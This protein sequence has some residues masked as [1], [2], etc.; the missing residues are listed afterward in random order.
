MKEVQLSII[1]P[2]YNSVTSL[3][4]AVH[5]ILNQTFTDFELILVDD[6]SKDGSGALCDEL[7]AADHRIRVIHQENR[8]VSAARNAGLNVASG[9]YIGWVDSD[10]WISPI[11]FELM[12]ER[13]LRYDADI[14]QSEHSRHRE[15][16]V[17]DKNTPMPEDEVLNELESLRRIYRDYGR[18]ANAMSLWSKIYKRELFEDLRFTEGSVFED[19]ECVPRLLYKGKKNVFFD[20]KLYQYVCREGSIVMSPSISGVIALMTHIERRMLWFSE[21]SPELYSLSMAHFFNHL[22]RRLCSPQFMNTEA[23]EKAAELLKKYR[24]TFKPCTTIYDR[25]TIRMLYFGKG[26]V[27]WVAKNEF[28]PIQ[29]MISKIMKIFRRN[30]T[31]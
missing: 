22:T 7:A 18:Y 29:I 10:D 12:M 11:M 23:Q 28:A 14:V 3:K 21:L 15:K 19:D 8:G 1:M 30:S 5:S 13:A 27:N 4:E 31:K 9:R 25:I 2:V 24:K 6:G 26:A 16:L 17:L 20:V